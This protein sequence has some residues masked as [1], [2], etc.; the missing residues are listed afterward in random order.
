MQ[1]T[2]LLCL[3]AVALAAC[4]KKPLPIESVESLVANPQRLRELREACK[5]DH[6]EVGD[7]QCNSVAEA[8]R[9]RFLDGG[10][11]PYAADPVTLPAPPAAESAP[12]E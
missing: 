8:T 4:E 7:A 12:K 1:R 5:A 9:R 3:C 10:R 2:L 11:S 6:A